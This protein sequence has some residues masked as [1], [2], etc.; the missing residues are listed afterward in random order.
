MRLLGNG[1]DLTANWGGLLVGFVPGVHQAFCLPSVSSFK[2]LL[3]IG[4]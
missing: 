3:F 2:R 1:Q 4:L